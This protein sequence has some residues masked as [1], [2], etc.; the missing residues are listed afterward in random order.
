MSTDAPIDLLPAA[1]AHTSSTG[2]GSS[3]VCSAVQYA[4]QNLIVHRDIKPSNILVTA[5]GT[6]KLLDFGTATLVAGAD[7]TQTGTGLMTVAYA[8]PEQLA[9]EAVRP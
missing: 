2:C 1:R 5:G 6:A 7:A 9:G 8:S 4:H 3:Q